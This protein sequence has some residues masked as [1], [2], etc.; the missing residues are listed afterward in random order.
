M[1]PR[2]KRKRRARLAVPVAHKDGNR[3]TRL[4]Q[5]QQN[6]LNEVYDV[7]EHAHDE[8]FTREQLDWAVKLAW[9]LATQESGQA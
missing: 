9:H 7:I 2:S 4:S 3:V 8:G 5:G 1:T 6:V